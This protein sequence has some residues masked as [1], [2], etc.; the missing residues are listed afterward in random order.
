MKGQP[1]APTT[2]AA[3]C[4]ICF[5]WASKQVHARKKTRIWP[6][7]RYSD[8]RYFNLNMTLKIRDFFGPSVLFIPKTLICVSFLRE[9]AVF[10]DHFCEKC[11]VHFRKKPHSITIIG[12]FF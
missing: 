2:G 1:G 4:A 5:M 10:F 9:L 6:E 12:F 8:H 3:A 7:S 11:M